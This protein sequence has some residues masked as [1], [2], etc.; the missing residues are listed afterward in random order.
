LG[1]GQL[2]LFKLLKLKKA[3]IGLSIGELDQSAKKRRLHRWR[4]AFSSLAAFRVGLPG[5]DGRTIGWNDQWSDLL[6]C[7][8]GHLAWPDRPLLDPA[9][10]SSISSAGSLSSSGGIAISSST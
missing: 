3:S 8:G 6:F 4:S 5:M 1:K 7:D 10:Q 2:L 9:S